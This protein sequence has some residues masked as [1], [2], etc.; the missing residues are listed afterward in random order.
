MRGPRYLY[1]YYIQVLLYCFVEVSYIFSY[2][3]YNTWMCSVKYI[4]HTPFNRILYFQLLFIQYM[5][6]KSTSL[7]PPLIGPFER[8]LF[9]CARFAIFM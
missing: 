2:F 3:L 6:V 9:I 7:T 8:R 1:Y 4:P 5:D